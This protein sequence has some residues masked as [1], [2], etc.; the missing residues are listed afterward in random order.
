LKLLTFDHFPSDS[1]VDLCSSK[2]YSCGV[3]C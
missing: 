3:G 1:A 2:M